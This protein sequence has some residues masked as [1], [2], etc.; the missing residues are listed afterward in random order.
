M[1]TSNPEQPSNST[2]ELEEVCTHGH[3]VRVREQVPS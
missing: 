3:L 2:T 1:D